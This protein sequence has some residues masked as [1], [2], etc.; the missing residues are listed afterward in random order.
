MPAQVHPDPGV[1][2]SSAMAMAKSGDVRI[3]YET[4]GDRAGRAVLLIAGLNDQLVYWSDRFCDRLV[5]HGIFVVR[6]DNRDV[7]LS[8]RAEH[9]YGLDDMAVDA[10]AV[11]D[12]LGL[13]RADV[14]S[15][16]LGGVIAQLLTLAYPERVRTLV[17]MSTFA[18][19]TPLSLTASELKRFLM[20]APLLDRDTYAEWFVS[21]TMPASPGVEEAFV[22]D[23]GARSFD[24]GVDHEGPSRQVEAIW[25]TKAWGEQ[26]SSIRT[27]TLVIH[28]D[29]DPLVPV[30]SGQAIADSIP[31]ARFDILAG[32][33]HD[34]PWGI[35]DQLADAIAEFLARDAG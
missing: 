18:D 6:F 23:I 16:S 31:G 20:T 4:V 11:L 27:P 28:G 29:A 3:A 14:V 5:S 9:A 25:K 24:R 26:L 1:A 33:G 30:S 21:G 19:P 32:R 2:D 35:E 15:T 13:D 17:L 8:S 12:A 22:R 7:G 34:L 10:I